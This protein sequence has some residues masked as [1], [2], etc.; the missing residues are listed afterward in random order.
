MRRGLTRVRH[1]S[2]YTFMQIG[3]QRSLAH[4]TSIACSFARQ[5]LFRRNHIKS[6]IIHA[7]TDPKD[8]K[9]GDEVEWKWGGAKH[10]S[11]HVSSPDKL[12][13]ASANLH[14]RKFEVDACQCVRVA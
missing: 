9:V 5:V 4:T 7:M 3:V 8:I 2:R 14:S 13:Y 11:G 12:L 1:A 6:P 10:I